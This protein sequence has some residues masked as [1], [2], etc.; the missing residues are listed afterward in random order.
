QPGGQ[1]PGGQQPSGQ[2]PGGQDSGRGDGTGEEVWVVGPD[3]QKILVMKS[4]G[5]GASAGQSGGGDQPGG[6][7]WGTGHD[8]NVSGNSTNPNMGT[9]DVTATG[10][11]T[12]KGPSRAEVIYGAAERGFVGKGYQKVFTEYETVAEKAIDKEDIPPG[13]RFY[14]QRYFQLIRPRE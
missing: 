6:K 2:R 12:G 3:G 14:V 7:S 8:P 5:G 13:Y 9:Q 11:D 4:A 1:Q 10:V